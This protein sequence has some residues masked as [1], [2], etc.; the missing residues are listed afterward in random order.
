MTILMGY[1][2][3]SPILQE[4]FRRMGETKWTHLLLAINIEDGL[5]P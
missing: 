3:V 1:A 2:K 5:N 4:T